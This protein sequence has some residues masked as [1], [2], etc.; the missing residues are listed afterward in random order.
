MDAFFQ[1]QKLYR[2]V[3]IF[4]QPTRYGSKGPVQYILQIF[5]TGHS[6]EE[7]KYCGISINGS[8]VTAID[9]FTY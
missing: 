6:F 2:S 4:G 1:M 3:L 9:V 7:K 5:L 8:D